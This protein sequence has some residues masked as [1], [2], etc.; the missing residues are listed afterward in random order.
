MRQYS[1]FWV[2]TSQSSIQSQW[3]EQNDHHITTLLMLTFPTLMMLLAGWLTSNC[4]NIWYNYKDIFRKLSNDDKIKTESSF[5]S[6]ESSLITCW[7][8]ELWALKM[9]HVGTFDLWPTHI[10]SAISSLKSNR[11]K[12]MICCW[13]SK[14]M[15]F[16]IM[17]HLIHRIRIQHVFQ[18]LSN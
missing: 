9:F 8:V 12:W 17:W 1:T 3:S 15:C 2:L 7:E 4:N 11:L 16:P 18:K 10:H 5:E 13:I 14:H 6:M